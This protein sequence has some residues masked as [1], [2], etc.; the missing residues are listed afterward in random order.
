MED[1]AKDAVREYLQKKGVTEYTEEL[2]GKVDS[3][4]TP[5]NLDMS[6]NLTNS[7]IKRDI[8]HHELT[9]S[10]LKF[11]PGKNKSRIKILKD[12]VS[13]LKDSLNTVKTMYYDRLNKREKNRLG[14]FLK[15]K[16]KTLLGVEKTRRFTFVFNQNESELSVGHH[17]DEIGNVCE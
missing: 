6:Y 5:F 1:K 2:W 12:S 9:I 10:E 7:M 17:L 13:L 14:I 15:L 11:N 3:V 8:S 16:Y 4:F